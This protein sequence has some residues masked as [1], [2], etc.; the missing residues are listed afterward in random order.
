M[1][2]LTDTAYTQIT[3]HFQSMPVWCLRK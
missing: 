1:K 3:K 2:N